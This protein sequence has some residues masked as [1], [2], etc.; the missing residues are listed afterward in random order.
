MMLIMIIYSDFVVWLK[1]LN[2]KL[3]WTLFSHYRHLFWDDS[4]ALRQFAC[5]YATDNV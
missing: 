5:A 4:C 2:E 1:L 3:L